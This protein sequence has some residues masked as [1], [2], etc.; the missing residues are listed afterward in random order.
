MRGNK[1]GIQ[2]YAAVH[3]VHTNCEKT[4]GVTSPKQEVSGVQKT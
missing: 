1:G 4:F 3:R 2:D